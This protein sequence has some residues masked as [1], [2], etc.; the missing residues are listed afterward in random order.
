MICVHS[1]LFIPTQVITISGARQLRKKLK[2]KNFNHYE[3]I[4]AWC[5]T[6]KNLATTK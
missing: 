4:R 5:M 2:K 6:E 1:Q 3:K